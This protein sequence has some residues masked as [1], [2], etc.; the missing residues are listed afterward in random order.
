MFD[1]QT[2]EPRYTLE[3]PFNPYTH[4][5]PSPDDTLVA[6]STG[7]DHSVVE[8]ATGREL[9]RKAYKGEYANRISFSQ[10]GSLLAVTRGKKINILQARTRELLRTLINPAGQI[11]GILDTLRFSPDGRYVSNELMQSV[12]FDP[13]PGMRHSDWSW[14]CLSSPGAMHYAVVWWRTEDG[15]FLHSV[16]QGEWNMADATF[17]PDG[18]SLA[19]ISPYGAVSIHDTVTGDLRNTFNDQSGQ[20]H[21]ITFSPDGSLLAVAS[22]VGITLWN[23]ALPRKVSSR[24]GHSMRIKDFSISRDATCAATASEDCSTLLWETSTC[25]PRLSISTP[26]YPHKKVSLAPDAGTVAIACDFGIISIYDT[27]TSERLVAWR[28]VED[29]PVVQL[30]HS[31]DGALLATSGMY[32]HDICLWDARTGDLRIRLTSHTDHVDSVRFTADSSHLVSTS[33]DTTCVLWNVRTGRQEREFHPFADADAF[34]PP[35]GGPVATL[36][37][38]YDRPVRFARR[39]DQVVIATYPEPVIELKPHP[40]GRHWTGAQGNHLIQLRL[41]GDVS[42]APGYKVETESCSCYCQ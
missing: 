12:D 31:P 39:E 1:W 25:Q 21:A 9:W 5:R 2:G 15:Q 28:A 10:D 36:F 27:A 42:T 40:D 41:E 38:N 18:Q 3:I 33:F 26:D 14:S 23:T 24:I 20:A 17:S 22:K 7:D 16:D 13:L 29:D 34:L 8:I 32:D 35:P 37:F 30:V 19:I 11:A 6:V 4:F